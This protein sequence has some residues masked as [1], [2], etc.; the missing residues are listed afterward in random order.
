MRSGLGSIGCP[1]PSFWSCENSTARKRPTLVEIL[2]RVTALSQWEKLLPPPGRSQWDVWILSFPWLDLKV[3]ASWRK[4]KVMSMNEWQLVGMSR[5]F[6]EG[7]V[8]VEL[9]RT[10]RESGHSAKPGVKLL[11]RHD[12]LPPLLFQ[13]HFSSPTSSRRRA[14]A[15]WVVLLGRAVFYSLCAG[16]S[17]RFLAISF[18]LNSL[19]VP[20]SSFFSCLDFWNVVAF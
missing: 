12:Q 14:A 5:Y 19:T 17:A 9:E 8:P 2:K 10:V 1:E 7:E 6:L 16:C 18:H 15:A 11:P 13:V 4:K 20:D 3:A